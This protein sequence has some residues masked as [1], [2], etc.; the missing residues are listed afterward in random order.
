MM[1]GSNGRCSPT[2]T[3]A[4]VAGAPAAGFRIYP[5]RVEAAFE[6]NTGF[7]LGRVSPGAARWLSLLAF[8]RAIPALAAQTGSGASAGTQSW[9]EAVC[10]LGRRYDSDSRSCGGPTQQAHL[11]VAVLGASSY[12][13]AEGTP[14][15][16]LASW[17]GAHV[18]AF[19][20]FQ[21]VPKLVVRRLRRKHAA[22]VTRR[23]TTALSFAT[24]RWLA[25]TE[26]SAI[27]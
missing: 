18:R 19:E 16:Q 25:Q 15:E 14:D 13:Y 5:R 11:F 23:W 20:F 12:A 4:T 17:I 8:L 6:S 27:C 7:A 1:S 24:W 2:V 26:A 21:G 22:T 9:R 3:P 10:R